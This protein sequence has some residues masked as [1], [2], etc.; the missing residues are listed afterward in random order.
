MEE[1]ELQRICREAGADGYIPKNQVLAKVLSQ[2]L[3]P[4]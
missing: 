1:K 3:G 4:E 2:Q